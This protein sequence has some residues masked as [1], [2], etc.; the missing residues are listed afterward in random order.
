VSKADQAAFSDLIRSTAHALYRVAARIVGNEADA[1]DGMQESY[2]R[3]YDAW[4]A[5]QFEGRSDAKAWLYRIVTN[6]AIDALRSRQ[7]RARWQVNME[8]EVSTLGSAEATAALREIA[9][10]MQQLPPDQRAA[11]VLK[12]MEGLTSAEVAQVMGCSEGAVE[13]RLV[14]AR[15]TLRGRMDRD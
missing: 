11:V 10:W 3:A 7:R 5:D 2:L 6:A 4:Q 8:A 14:R 1:E 9:Q 15:T 13:Q 12:E